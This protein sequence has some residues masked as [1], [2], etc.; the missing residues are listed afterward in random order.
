VN[1][2]SEP[3]RIEALDSPGEAFRVDQMPPLRCVGKLFHL[4]DGPATHL[5]FACCGIDQ[6][7]NF[8]YKKVSHLLARLQGCE[9]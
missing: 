2:D 8:P 1:L 9:F 6:L 5:S 7:R 3:T 4:E